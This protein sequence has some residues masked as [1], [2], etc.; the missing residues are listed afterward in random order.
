MLGRA[1]DDIYNL[2]EKTE[3]AI[4]NA[5]NVTSSATFV[6]AQKGT[7]RPYDHANIKTRPAAKHWLNILDQ[8]GHELG[9]VTHSDFEILKGKMIDKSVVVVVPV[10]SDDEPGEPMNQYVR[11]K[12]IMSAYKYPFHVE[13]EGRSFFQVPMKMKTNNIRLL[14]GDATLD[15]KVNTETQVQQI[16]LSYEDIV[17]GNILL[18][19]ARD[20]ASIE[21]DFHKTFKTMEFFNVCRCIERMASEFEYDSKQLTQLQHFFISKQ[22]IVYKKVNEEMRKTVA[23]QNDTNK[24]L[25]QMLADTTSQLLQEIKLKSTSSLDQDSDLY[26]EWESLT[27]HLKENVDC[28]Y[29]DSLKNSFSGFQPYNKRLVNPHHAEADIAEE[30]ATLFPRLWRM[31]EQS[32]RTQESKSNKTFV[33]LDTVFRMARQRNSRTLTS[34]AAINTIYLL[35]QGQNK[36]QIRPRVKTGECL[37]VDSTYSTLSEFAKEYHELIK[38]PFNNNKLISY[39][40]RINRTVCFRYLTRHLNVDASP[41]RKM[42]V[43]KVDRPSRVTG[44]WILP[45]H[46]SYFQFSIVDVR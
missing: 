16:L 24:R 12:N 39:S 33:A 3:E 35:A 14:N 41:T 23:A 18:F 4:K 44:R 11:L 34:W 5:L 7:K 21:K 36:A 27:E 45:Q 28:I 37:S 20:D 8:T 38:T 19:G 46:P 6:R 40:Y 26:C 29:Y 32:I 10:P 9:R 22:L 30:I 13:Q 31:I 15:I 25:N 42:L 43:G 1:P 17:Q 2:A